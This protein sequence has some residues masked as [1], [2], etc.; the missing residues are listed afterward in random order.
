LFSDLLPPEEQPTVASVGY[1]D[2]LPEDPRGRK[3]DHLSIVR[4]DA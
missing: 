2:K 4:D 3:R 1:W